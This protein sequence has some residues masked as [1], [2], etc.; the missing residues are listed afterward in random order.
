LIDA[1]F[2]NFTSDLMNILPSN[3]FLS[4]KKTS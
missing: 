2:V 3:F 4:A 1:V